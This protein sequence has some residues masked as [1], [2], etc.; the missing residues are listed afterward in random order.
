MLGFIL[1]N[2]LKM[3]SGCFPVLKNRVFASY[4]SIKNNNKK[5]KAYLYKN[6]KNFNLKL[7]Q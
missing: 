7:I 1:K 5:L 4:F 3:S 2:I 6:P